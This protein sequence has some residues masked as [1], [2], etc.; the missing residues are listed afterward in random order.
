MYLLY[1]IVITKHEITQEK[2][3]RARGNKFVKIAN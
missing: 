3:N 1:D 2:L